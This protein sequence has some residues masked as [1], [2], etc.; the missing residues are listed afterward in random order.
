M[1]FAPRLHA[2]RGIT[3]VALSFGTAG[4]A[5]ACGGES[6]DADTDTAGPGTLTLVTQGTETDSD[7]GT[8][9]ATTSGVDT[10]GSTAGACDPSQV[11]GEACCEADEAC[12]DN[13]VCRLDCGTDNPCGDLCCDAAGGELCYVGQCIVPGAVCSAAAC[14]TQVGIRVRRW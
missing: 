3:L 11:C 9:D 13:G 7:A 8:T 6:G 5:S 14:A 1:R 2:T 10:G 12:D 4:F